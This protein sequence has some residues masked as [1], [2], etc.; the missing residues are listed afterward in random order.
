[1][2]WAR[3]EEG[4]WGGGRWGVHRRHLPWGSSS[5]SLH[6][7]LTFPDENSESESDS[8][9]RFKGETW[10][11]ESRDHFPALVEGYLSAFAV[12]A[13]QSGPV[14]KGISR[15]DTRPKEQGALGESIHSIMVLSPVRLNSD[16]SP[17][18]NLRLVTLPYFLKPFIVH[19]G[20]P[21][22]CCGSGGSEMCSRF[23]FWL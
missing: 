7:A 22:K 12:P 6:S 14:G 19:L 20:L 13:S 18:P 9:D 1:M 16:I 2:S 15:Q 17:F 5:A 11:L 23:L 10:L 3:G 21:G 4:E 8:D